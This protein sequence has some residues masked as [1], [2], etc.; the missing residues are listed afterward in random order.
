M[1]SPV[2]E[3]QTHWMA[4]CVSLLAALFITGCSDSPEPPRYAPD[5]ASSTAGARPLD[6]PSRPL[7]DPQRAQASP[8]PSD[9]LATRDAG[10][11]ATIDAAAMPAPAERDSGARAPMT[12]TPDNGM[13]RECA[14]LDVEVEVSQAAVD[15]VWVIDSSGSMRNE[16]DTIQRGLNAF[17]RAVAE[18]S[19]DMRVVVI[20]DRKDFDV[21]AP[22]GQDPQHFQ[23][24]DRKVGSHDALETFIK[25][26]DDYADFL[27]PE[28]KLELIAV[29]DDESRLSATAFIADMGARAGKPFRLH[30]IASERVGKDACDGAKKP[31]DEYY[32][33]AMLTE[34][35]TLSVCNDVT[36]ALFDTL[37]GSVRDSAGSP[38]TFAVPKAPM[39]FD[40]DPDLLSVHWTPTPSAVPEVIPP[41]DTEARCGLSGWFYAEPSAPDALTLCPRTCEQL[42]GNAVHVALECRV[43]SDL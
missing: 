15:V 8:A 37:S 10:A 3:R 18:A 28:A 38:C 24:L 21:P 9:R 12:A 33:A 41:V 26:F 14:G 7:D 19:I 35:L 6:L 32:A 27:R 2:L 23:L 22:L 43:A 25:E 34:G 30:A 13:A 17:A 16:R 20:T 42:E 29:T 4:G 1:F 11:S 5:P 31:G 36:P 39:G 40:F